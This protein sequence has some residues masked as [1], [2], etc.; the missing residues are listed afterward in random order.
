VHG[1]TGRKLPVHKSLTDLAVAINSC[2]GPR[3]KATKARSGMKGLQN[4][5]Q[6][7]SRRITLV[8]ARR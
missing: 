6:Y 3:E 1:L 5:I 8:L 7:N 2:T 4:G